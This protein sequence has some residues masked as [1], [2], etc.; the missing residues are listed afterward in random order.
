[1]PRPESVLVEAF[2]T[3]GETTAKPAD[4]VSW[5][6]RREWLRTRLEQR[7]FPG[8]SVEEVEVHFSTMP[9]HYWERVTEDEL[10]WALQTVHGFLKLVASP[11]VPAT[12]P[13]VT[14]RQSGLVGQ[15]RVMLCTWDRQ[16]LLA[17]A[18]AAF[19][20]V[21]L[22]IVQAE[23]FTRSDNV[24]LDTFTI[25]GADGCSPAA[26]SQIEQMGFLLEGALSEPPRFASVWACSRH[27]YLAPL[28]QM[29]SRIT[30]DND[31][32]IDSTLVQ[33]E[34]ADRLG[35]LYDILQ[36][37][38]DAGFSVK[39]AR[40]KTENK[41]ARDIIYVTN[42]GGQKVLDQGQLDALCAKLQAALTVSA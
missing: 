27:K 40:I 32:S 31:I 8:I 33:I 11:E 36:A 2:L 3:Q 29:V 4:G 20:A 1:M 26:P 34:A 13:F 41:L 39:Q 42:G 35:L 16:G 7:Q 30:W 5:N 17:K 15:V 6:Q 22:N 37:I 19:S 9:A 23:V 10:I 12:A 18:A 28:S 24:V 25:A 14:W 21:R 38:T